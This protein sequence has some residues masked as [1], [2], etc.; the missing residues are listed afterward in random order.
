MDF[1]DQGANVAFFEIRIE[2]TTTAVEFFRVWT[3]NYTGAP[4]GWSGGSAAFS[5][6]AT[7][8]ATLSFTGTGASWIGWRGPQQG[9]ANVYLDNVAVGSIDAYAPAN[10]VQTVLYSSPPLPLGP[11]TLAIEVTRTKN[12]ASSDY[13]V[14]VDAFDVT[15]A[16]TDT[17][18]R[19]RHWSSPRRCARSKL[20]SWR[21]GSSK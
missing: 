19:R 5:V 3:Q 14:A 1:G 4:G 8:R 20:A 7:G 11:H 9:I 16:P 18:P 17:T 13:F 12:A 6:E 10:A 15:G 2:E 21:R